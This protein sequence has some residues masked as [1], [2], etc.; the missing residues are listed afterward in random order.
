MKHPLAVRQHILDTLIRYIET[1]YS[2]RSPDLANERR[3]LLQDESLVQDVYLE[4]V[5]PYP[6]AAPATE[7]LAELGLD[8]PLAE[9]L[10]RAVFQA[11][12]ADAVMLRPH[13]R[14]SIDAVAA[15]LNPVITS[16]T[17]SGKTEA[18]LLPLLAGIAKERAQ[19]RPDDVSHWWRQE[20]WQPLRQ[21]TSHP[22]AMRSL[23]LY[24]TNALVEDQMMRLR[25]S[26]RRLREL[27]GPHLWF[28]RYT[29]ATLGHGEVPARGQRSAPRRVQEVAGQVRGLAQAFT[30]LQEESSKLLGEVCDPRFDEMVTRWDMITT[31]PD[32]M[33]TNYSMLNV[34]LMRQRED[35]LFE[36][37]KEW[38]EADSSH[39][40]TLV[41][42]ELHLYRGTQGAEVAL[43][44]RNFLHRLG[45]APQSPQLRIIATSASLGDSPETYLQSFF[46]VPED[47]FRVISGQPVDADPRGATLSDCPPERLSH[48]VADACRDA[49]TGQLRA[50]A[51][52][53]VAERLGGAAQLEQALQTMV[54]HR[55]QDGIPLRA[56][57]FMRTLRGLWAC[58][59]PSCTAVDREEPLAIGRL[60]PSP[61]SVCS[62]GGRVLELLHCHHCGD[63]SLGGYVPETA[64][65]VE[66]LSG[67][68]DRPSA[69]PRRV[70]ER[71]R[72]EY[73]WYWPGK[74]DTDAAWEHTV[75][76]QK[77]SFRF[78]PAEY[79]PAIGSLSVPPV[80]GPTGATG[81]VVQVS[82][83]EASAV[84]ALPTMCP[85]CGHAE[86]KP[87]DGDVQSVRSPIR[88]HTQ[89]QTQAGRLLV[90]ELTR[91]VGETEEE[92]KTVLFSDSR[93]AAARMSAGLAQTHFSD[94]LRQVVDRQLRNQEDTLPGSIRAVLA[95]P[96]AP[97]PPAEMAAIQE[98]AVQR[99]DLLDAY[100][101]EQAGTLIEE[102]RTLIHEWE[103]GRQAEGV[104]VGW[105]DLLVS[106]RSELIALGVAP[107]GPF[108]SLQTL[109]DGRTPWYL[110]FDPPEPGLWT[111]LASGP[112]VADEVTKLRDSQV[113]ELASSLFGSGVRDLDSAGLAY[114]TVA[115]VD[116]DG[117]LV[118]S[119][120]RLWLGAGRWESQSSSGS[121]GQPRVVTDFIERVAQRRGVEASDLQ[122]VV[123]RSLTQL[124]QGGLVNIGAVTCPLE[125]VAATDERWRCS[126]CRRVHAQP[127]AGVCTRIRCTGD[128]VVESAG[129]VETDYYAWLADQAPRRMA[130][131][132]LTGQ[133]R[134][135]EVQQ[136]RQRWFRGALLPQ[137]NALTTP[138]DVLSVTTTM[139]VG[140]DIG[141][142]RSTVM[143]NM[144]PQRF[145][146]QQRVGRAGRSGQTFSFAAT[147]CRDQTHDDYYFHEAA[148]ITGDPPPPPFIDTAR[149]SV[150]RR[151]VAAEVLRCAFRD[152][153]IT[154]SARP[155]VH[156]NFGDVENWSANKK[157]IE[158]F[159]ATD[160]CVDEIAY[161]FTALTGLAD[162]EVA[163]I[164]DWVRTGLVGA[165]D[166]AVENPLSTQ[167]ELSERL[168]H[169]GVLPVF[170]FTTKVRSLYYARDP[171]RNTPLVVS[172][173]SLEQA[174]TFFA[175]GHTVV[176]DG[177]EY[178][179][180]GFAAYRSGDASAT[181]AMDPITS[182]IRVTRCEECGTTQ[183]ADGSSPAACPT[184]GATW[185][186]VTYYL[187]DG[188]WAPDR[189]DR[190]SESAGS[191][192]RA[193]R[194]ELGWTNISSE[195]DDQV[196]NMRL[197]TLE[198][199]QLL[200]LNDNRDQLFRMYAEGKAVRVP[201]GGI[202][203]GEGQ[204]LRTE[205][206]IADVRVTDAALML[207]SSGRHLGGALDTHKEHTPWGL[208]ALT[209]LAAAVRV[210]AHAELDVDP[211]DLRVG[212]QPRFI[213]GVRTQSIYVADSLENGAGYA[214]EL[215]TD[216]RLGAVLERIAGPLAD[217]WSGPGHDDCLPSC[218]DCLRSY[219]NLADHP[220][221]DWRLALDLA[222]I[223]LD[224]EWDG[225]RWLS[226]SGRACAALQ[227][228]FDG[229][230]RTSVE[231]LDVLLG[232]RRAVVVGHPLWR[233]DREGWNARQSAAAA[234]LASDGLDVHMWDVKTVLSF[235]SRVGRTLLEG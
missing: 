10:T 141:S 9:L 192:A 214:V 187:P 145:N 174:V 31:P 217:R 60:F 62:C 158:R 154:A 117:G 41:V 231:G 155:S 89:G 112:M 203:V 148:R 27:G 179:A 124:V 127:S 120:V 61:T 163:S 7:A 147:L 156:G 220:W 121:S 213:D 67:E 72:S 75:G 58:S 106:V 26:V 77:V 119:V 17:G 3:L 228:G 8:D 55:Q 128:L 85:A 183:A 66:F 184:C 94:L 82:T 57:L 12:E 182:H 20:R 79:D 63:V 56:H 52:A 35:V 97:L 233:H 22:A 81:W 91:V 122:Q 223:A 53:T 232:G 51:A 19:G 25:R 191:A 6:A 175:P 199:A 139:E 160:P 96:F 138:L 78:V 178:V 185:E 196:G 1:T 44:V 216:G 86:T 136:Q 181:N 100:R 87:F 204:P 198:R 212:L 151:G 103:A 135:Y 13:Q 157:I 234:A 102:Q 16:G 168:A 118:P 71:P 28:G 169:A 206:G 186:P 200:V 172:D 167:S 113:A 161:R 24:P 227:A 34:M 15:G 33:V 193:D 225:G 84:A 133:T 215:A 32:V 230:S 173:R 165:I 2:L 235:P 59:N 224:R 65:T 42:D 99:P 109:S 129:H 88:A 5:P 14:E 177:Y 105:P 211:S 201:A 49:D 159:C 131:A 111:K 69:W 110:A 90:S 47:R 176:K 180:G 162:H 210:G 209:S 80:S 194:P 143:G 146:Y 221:L 170:G 39:V 190:V 171:R 140:V 218:Q 197:W 219:D 37:T 4:P 45:L 115:G 108:A 73:R 104:R 132:E 134:P 50:T 149:V 43:V 98:L 46:G 205:G 130:V 23:I 150:I 92:R 18:F 142:L 164:I 222:D 36:Q 188:F 29:G 70:F 202:T 144:P 226:Q 21:P 83:Q 114:A 30:E 107:G 229:V 126:V 76:G 68:A 64:E 207:I 11:D 40:F 123:D 54:D 152:E 74:R 189:S 116:E 95:N 208:A 101:S 93:D 195:P 166:D 48:V 125:L 153:S 137:E 38:L